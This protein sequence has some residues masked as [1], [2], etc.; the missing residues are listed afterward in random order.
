MGS[1]YLITIPKI[2]VWSWHAMNNWLHSGKPAR[3]KDHKIVISD[4][5]NVHKGDNQEKWT[6]S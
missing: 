3:K 5:K 4:A 2:H 1:L 6:V